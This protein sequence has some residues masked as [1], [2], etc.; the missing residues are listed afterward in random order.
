MTLSQNG[1]TANDITQTDVQ[2]IPG[3]ERKLRLRKGDAGWLLRRIGAFI[4]KFVENIDEPIQDDWGYAERNIRGSETT[5]SNHASGTAMD[6]N[7]EKHQLGA[8]GT[9]S[10]TEKATIHN[11]LR[12][13]VDPATGR[14]VIRWGEDYVYRKDGMHFEIVGTPSAVARV[15]AKLR[16]TAPAPTGNTPAQDVTI[17]T[18]AIRNGCGQEGTTAPAMRITDNAYGDCRAF[19][20]WARAKGWVEPYQEQGWLDAVTRDHRFEYGA[21]ILTDIVRRVQRSNGLVADGVFGPKTGAI[22]AKYGYK[23]V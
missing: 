16:N 2:L 21:Q 13:Y 4:D 10:T 1:W 5:V 23:I 18:W 19:V 17:S 9:W 7:A 20:A 12:E 11:H 6:I 3:T 8:T 14:N 22:M 15:A